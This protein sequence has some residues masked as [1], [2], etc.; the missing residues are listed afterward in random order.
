M[1]NIR[2]IFITTGISVLFGVYSIYHI[3]EYL[4]I[5]HNTRTKEISDLKTYINDINTKY[6]NLHSKYDILE[7]EII[8]TN[9]EVSKLQL[10]ISE[11]HNLSN[12]IEN[13]IEQDIPSEIVSIM[14]TDES[15]ICDEKCDLNVDIPRLHLETMNS[16]N[17]DIDPEFMESFSSVEYDH[18]QNTYI[19]TNNLEG[20]IHSISSYHNSIKTS[21]SRSGS[22]TDINWT[23]LTKKFLFG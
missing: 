9:N 13:I 21:R 17:A 19:N 18:F 7:N 6:I 10:Q 1:M 5:M 4:K 23:G 2:H 14:D 12:N 11:L 20:S 22:L 8:K 15:I 3:I 16:N